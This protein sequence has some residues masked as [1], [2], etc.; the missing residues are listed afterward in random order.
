MQYLVIGRDGDDEG[1]QNR[2]LAAR[3]AHIALG[4]E[5]VKSGNMLFGVAMLNSGG[6]M[7]GSTLIVDF[8]SRVHLD[9]WLKIEPYIT[10]DVW[11]SIEVQECRVGPSFTK[12]LERH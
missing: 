11:Q 9:E 5:L 8:E 3:G 4:D 12:L 6:Q 7:V 2:R 10:G 1:A